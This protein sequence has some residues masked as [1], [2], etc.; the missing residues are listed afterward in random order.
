MKT[1]LKLI[2]TIVFAVV[3]A[4][5]AEGMLA[6]A[7]FEGIDAIIK[8]LDELAPPQKLV[9][10]LDDCIAIAIANNPD[11]KVKQY[12]LNSVQGDEMIDR[13]R[14]F[15]HW[16]VIGNFGRSQG[17]LLKT[18][19]T[20]YN[21]RPV[22][23]LGGLETSSYSATSGA[24]GET[25]LSDLAAQYGI[26]DISSLLSMIPPE[27]QSMIP[28]EMLRPQGG[29]EGQG[30]DAGAGRSAE[31]IPGIDMDELNALL[32]QME[33]F[34]NYFN[35][36]AS[37]SQRTVVNNELAI[38]YSR[39]L[40]E[41]GRDS[42]SSVQIRRNR[43]LAI[44]NYQQ[45]LRDVISSVRSGFFIIILKK[46]QIE[47][48]Q[49]LLQ[50]YEE[51]LWKLRKRFEIAKDVPRIDVLTA[52]LDVLNE[53]SRINTL[54]SELVGNKLELLN[55]LDLSLGVEVDFAGEIPSFNY[56]LKDIVRLTKENGFHIAYLTEEYKESLNEFNQLAWDYKPILSGRMGWENH[57]L[58]AGLTLNNSNQTYGLDLGVA[59]YTNVPAG[60]SS[61]SS[62]GAD[63]NYSLSIGVAWNL[64]DNMERGG[65]T[66]KYVEKLNQT[67]AELNAEI[68]KEELEARKAYQN[69][70]DAVEQ[71]KIQIEIVENSKQR[72]DI[73]R[74]LREYGKVNEFQLDSLRNT[75]F[76]DQERLFSIQE[77]VIT[78]QENLRRI[79]GVFY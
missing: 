5:F 37:A 75:F 10:T 71:L 77:N 22:T 48:R 11:L 28:Q 35:Q 69:L 21:P 56:N 70:L 46:Q 58:A 74:K 73:T 40:I 72:L 45:K 18:Y 29:P 55:I 57:N 65:V 13:A 66:L 15:S 51:K 39:R 34:L 68:N 64:Y 7:D 4:A 2:V 1:S 67:R 3:F 42:S 50:E 38:R 9:L 76:S 19:Y 78:A 16:D 61:F 54:R 31:Q 44:Y 20:T 32:D 79:M 6:R 36:S 43:R 59:G 47:T 23:S 14:F 25:D 17:S 26:S 53:K 8:Q 49:K 63:H 41:W 33:D 12:I 27:F 52:E 60:T 62:S 30:D 24:S